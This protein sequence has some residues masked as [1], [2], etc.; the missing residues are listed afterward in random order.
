MNQAQRKRIAEIVGI[1][2]P[3]QYEIAAM[4]DAEQKKFDDLDESMYDSEIGEEFEANSAELGE[5]AAYI[6]DSITHLETRI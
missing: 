2:K 4:S 6:G 3:L 5:A 1:L